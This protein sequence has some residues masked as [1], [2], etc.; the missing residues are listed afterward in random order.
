[1]I[2]FLRNIV[3]YQ[4]SIFSGSS[5]SMF[6]SKN[7]L[8]IILIF[9]F[10]VAPFNLF[11]KPGQ[12]KFD[13][14]TQP[15]ELANTTISDML[16]D[17]DGFLWIGTFY[18]GLIRYDGHRIKRYMLGSESSNYSSEPVGGIGEDHFG[19]LWVASPISGLWRLNRETDQFIHFFPNSSLPQSTSVTAVYK[20]FE[21]SK[22]F[23]WLS[24]PGQG[25]FRYDQVKEKLERFMPDPE[26]PHGISHAYTTDIFEDRIGN[27]WISTRWNLVRLNQ[28]TGKILPVTILPDSG[29]Y[30]AQLQ[31][32]SI[33]EDMA[34]TVWVG[35]FK[36]GLFHIDKENNQLIPFQYDNDKTKTFDNAFI[37]IIIEDQNQN[38]WI[39]TESLGLVRMD[40]DR[41]KLHFYTRQDGL[42][43]DI[44]QQI[45]LTPGTVL[46]NIT[47]IHQVLMNLCTNAGHAMEETGG[48]LTLLLEK[49]EIEPDTA[50]IF[51]DLLPG[52]Y[53]R[54]SISDTGKGM[55]REIID[56]IFEPFFTTKKVGK[57]T[58]MGLSV[59]KNIIENHNGSIKVYSEPGQGSTF[60]I[61]LPLLDSKL[62]TEKEQGII[63]LPTGTEKILFI[64]DDELLLDIGY[65][66]ISSLGYSVTVEQSPVNAL[67]MFQSNP[68]HFDLLITDLTMPKLSGIDLAKIVLAIKPDLP[69]L[70]CSGLNNPDIIESAGKVGIRTLVN[71]PFSRQQI[72][73]TIREALNDGVI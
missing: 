15:K 37:R 55:T 22:G 6:L 3:Q 48:T 31:A 25:L 59:V 42:P 50:D 30:N 16:Q 72:A 7:L 28:D 10:F 38:L 8:F 65:N 4:R 61:Y 53:A 46:G 12:L 52:H 34:G 47:Q 36:N 19:N 13:R 57:G 39:G 70:L 35:T 33:C 24:T 73:R 62:V 41:Q 2:I 63:A 32:I 51:S 71:K 66:L 60:N 68:G 5:T 45:N 64:D 40:K 58:G 56:R 20:I 14:I 54:I 67:G 69:V 17:S 49:V 43:S 23:L 27:L 21:D 29:K 44:N 26:N 1:M 11:A 9:T 18:S